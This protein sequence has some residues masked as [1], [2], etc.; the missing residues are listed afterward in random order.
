V[1][2]RKISGRLRRTLTDGQLASIK[3]TMHL[4]VEEDEERGLTLTQRRFCDACEKARPAPGFIQYG[5]YSL[6]NACATSYEIAQAR[7]MSL[8]AGQY[9][10]DNRFGETMAYAVLEP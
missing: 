1:V 5:R 3:A 10:R 2:I 7:G 9:V 6:C 8:S 4:F